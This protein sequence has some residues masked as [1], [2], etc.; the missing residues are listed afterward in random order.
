MEGESAYHILV[1][2]NSGRK[3]RIITLLPSSALAP[4]RFL[5]ILHLTEFKQEGELQCAHAWAQPSETRAVLAIFQ[6]YG[7]KA[8]RP[9]KGYSDNILREGK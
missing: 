1:C 5:I 6:E 8:V 3:Y 7:S 4:L 9:R 2:D